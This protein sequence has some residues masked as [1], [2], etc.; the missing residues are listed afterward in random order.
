MMALMREQLVSNS[1]ACSM[2]SGK[3]VR[4]NLFYSVLP[5]YMIF[6]SIR[7]IISAGI[8]L[9]L[10]TME[11]ISWPISVFRS[12]SSRI[13]AFT[14]KLIKPCSSLSFS[15][16]SFLRSLLLAP[17]LM[18]MTHGSNAELIKS[19]VLS[20]VC[21]VLTC[22]KFVFSFKYGIKS[23]DE[24]VYSLIFWERMADET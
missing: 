13:S 7:T 4:I 18:W 14:S 6:L 20:N 10:W 24:V 5:L 12:F 19:I 2:I 15:V 1:F 11:C 16:I 23:F 22:E 3:L 9:L 8:I 17:G 21:S